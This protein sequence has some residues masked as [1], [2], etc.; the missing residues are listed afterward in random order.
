MKIAIHYHSDQTTEVFDLNSTAD[1]NAMLAK[2]KGGRVSID[3]ESCGLH[4]EAELVAALET[5]MKLARPVLDP[6]K[7]AEELVKH[8]KINR[9]PPR[10]TRLQRLIH[11]KFDVKGSVRRSGRRV[12]ATTP[13]NHRGRR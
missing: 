12:I 11:N 2:I 13:R 5:A 4:G 3:H 8:C 9:E 1:V 7:I 10:E 6:A